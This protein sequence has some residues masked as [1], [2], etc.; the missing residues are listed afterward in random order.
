MVRA[1]MRCVGRAEAP[2]PLQLVF[3]PCRGG[4]PAEWR[5]GGQLS[6]CSGSGS[7]SHRGQPL[8]P[9]AKIGVPSAGA[10]EGRKQDT[11]KREAFD[12]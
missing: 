2:L 8:R 12:E 6:P 3:Y 4:W 9:T 11:A 10:G 5:E 7:A 1:D